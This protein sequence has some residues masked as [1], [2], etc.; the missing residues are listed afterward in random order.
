MKFWETFGGL[1]GKIGLR[2]ARLACRSDLG[3]ELKFDS[4]Y[5]FI[6]SDVS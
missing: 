4:S 6:S 2:G 3:F 5:L 1:M